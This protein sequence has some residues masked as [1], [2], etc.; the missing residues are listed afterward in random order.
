MKKRKWPLVF[1]GRCENVARN[2]E[3]LLRQNVEQDIA[4][5]ASYTVVTSSFVI[6][7]AI[8]IKG[9]K[10]AADVGAAITE[11]FRSGKNFL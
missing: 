4:N 11:L 1:W 5:I 2:L 10:K 3:S 8:I 6:A 9:S 7:A